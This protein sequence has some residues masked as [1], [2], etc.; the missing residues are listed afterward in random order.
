MTGLARRATAVGFR[1]ATLPPRAGLWVLAGC[2]LLAGALG[3]VQIARSSIATGDACAYYLPLAMQVRQV[4]LEAQNPTIPPLQPLLVGLLSMPLPAEPQTVDRVAQGLSLACLMGVVV[5]GYALAAKIHSYRVAAASAVLIATGLFLIRLGA[6]AGPEMLYTLWLTL[7]A[8][9]LV[10]YLRRPGAVLGALAG[11][12]AALAALTRSEGVAL[13]A[14]APTVLA[15]VRLTRRP[16]DWVP[17]LRDLA[18]CLTLIALTC[19]PRAMWMTRQVGYP[20][21]DARLLDLTGLAEV[22][23]AAYRP[24]AQVGLIRCAPGSAEPGP[25][26]GERIQEAGETLFTGLGQ[27]VWVGILL[28]LW[29]GRRLFGRR[30][31]H[32]I[33]LAIIV[34]QLVMVLPVK[35]DRRYVVPL[36]PLAALWGAAGL[37]AMSESL[38]PLGGTLGKLGRSLR[39]QLAGLALLAVVMALWSILGTNVGQ[40]H[41]ELRRAGLL[42]AQRLGPAPTVLAESSEAPYY[43][44]GRWLN[45]VECP[46]DQPGLSPEQ[47]AAILREHDVDA[48]VYRSRENW[49]PWLG[50]F[51]QR[52]PP[53]SPY[54][55]ARLVARHTRDNNGQAVTAWVINAKAWLALQAP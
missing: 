40:R 48:I 39:W 34:V 35:M 44:S 2:V 50:Q 32:W 38:R 53:Q 30:G 26:L 13:L 1:P 36:A 20:V 47:L 5:A 45:V 46:P 24:P 17:A 43:A 25:S 22:D 54:L 3:G 42:I 41:D 16:V 37:V 10:S 51:A 52:Q 9:T 27:V 49:A 8:L 29:K 7:L 18:L 15:V 55:M 11:Q 12:L 19:A 33:L 28:Y 31:S 23:P 14:L 4:G 6:L 21:L